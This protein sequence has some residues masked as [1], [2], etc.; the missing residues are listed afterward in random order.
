MHAVCVFGYDVNISPAV[1]KK[2]PE[3]FTVKKDVKSKAAAK[4]WL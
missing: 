2:P 4:K 1:K 3:K